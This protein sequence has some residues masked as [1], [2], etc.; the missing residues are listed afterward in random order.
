MEKRSRG[1]GTRIF[2]RI[3]TS[4]MPES[5]SD[6]IGDAVELVAGI[7]EAYLPECYIAGEKEP[8]QFLVVSVDSTPDISEIVKHLAEKLRGVLPDGQFIDILPFSSSSMPA[9]ARI[10]QCRI[11]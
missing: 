10:P 9:E 3:P 8:R 1:I 7:D 5:L 6:A 11:V 4:P 2:F